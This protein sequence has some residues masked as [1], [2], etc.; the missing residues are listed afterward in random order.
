[1]KG[2]TA[3]DR[4]P[5]LPA[6]AL[7]QPGTLCAREPARFTLEQL[8][9]AALLTLSHLGPAQRRELWV[10]PRWLGCPLAR[11]APTV[12]ERFGVYRAIAERNAAA[13][14]QRSRALLEGP[15]VQGLDWERFLLLTA[16]LGAHAS[17]QGDEA[18][19]LWQAHAPSL[20]AAGISPV[21]VY[22]A[23]WR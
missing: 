20:H 4:T 13:M 17:G 12:R 1:V 23:T 10:E 16:M 9:A 21:E 14:L 6:V 19:R 3:A 22:L 11:T 8:H 7:R 2:R 5:P 15:P 18:R